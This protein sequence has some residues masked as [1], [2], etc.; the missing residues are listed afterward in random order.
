[1][2]NLVREFGVSQLTQ[3]LAKSSTRHNRYAITRQLDSKEKVNRPRTIIL[4]ERNLVSDRIEGDLQN[5]IGSVCSGYN[6]LV[7]VLIVQLY[8]REVLMKIFH[9]FSNHEANRGTQ[10]PKLVTYINAK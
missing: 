8:V 7:A 9:A 6:I 3:L 10:T 2:P 4:L 1:V 5:L